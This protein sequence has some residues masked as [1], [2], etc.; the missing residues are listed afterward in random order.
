MKITTISL[1]KKYKEKY[2][3]KS[4]W[5]V[6]FRKL[7]KEIWY[8][9]FD[10]FIY[11]KKDRYY[12]NKDKYKNPIS[13]DRFIYKTKRWYSKEE[14]IQRWI[15]KK[16]QIRLYKQCKCWWTL[17]KFDDEYI[18]RNCLIHLPLDYEQNDTNKEIS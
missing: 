15:K 16:K 8:D 6:L 17:A 2:W 12:D 10:K 7:F 18:C 11:T 1:W 14:A 4:H 9:V 5:I 13:Y 3:D